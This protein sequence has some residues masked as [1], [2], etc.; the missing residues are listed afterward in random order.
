[1]VGA[2]RLSRPK[3]APL[4]LS[5]SGAGLQIP[6]NAIEEALVDQSIGLGLAVQ[7][8]TPGGGKSQEFLRSRHA[9]VQP[10]HP[11]PALRWPDCRAPG[12]AAR[13]RSRFLAH[14]HPS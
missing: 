2:T 11:A 4:S 1:M 10:P 8:R 9:V 6:R 3:G 12:H 13:R 5:R 14:V 7:V